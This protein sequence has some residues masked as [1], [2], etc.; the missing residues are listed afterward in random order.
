M[1]HHLSTLPEAQLLMWSVIISKENQ[2]EKQIEKEKKGEEKRNIV[3]EKER[4]K[5][6]NPSMCA[7]PVLAK[8]VFAE[9]GSSVHRVYE[10]AVLPPHKHCSDSLTSVGCWSASARPWKQFLMTVC[11]PVRI[12]SIHLN[13]VK[14]M[15]CMQSTDELHPH[16]LCHS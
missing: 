16:R 4:Q 12:E 1:I 7:W 10:C 13:C 3:K 9:Y 5:E 6:T 2:K 11:N 8:Q 14:F 15:P